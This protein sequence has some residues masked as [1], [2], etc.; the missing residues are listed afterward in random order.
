MVF[1][2]FFFNVFNQLTKFIGTRIIHSSKRSG[3]MRIN[4]MREMGKVMRKMRRWRDHDP[5]PD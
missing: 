2:L 1:S 5:I 4:Q 3:E